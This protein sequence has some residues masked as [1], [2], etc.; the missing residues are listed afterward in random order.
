[1]KFETFS[2]DSW[3]GVFDYIDTTSRVRTS[4]R[5]AYGLERANRAKSHPSL[6]GRLIQAHRT[7]NGT[8]CL[9]AHSFTFS[10]A[11]AE[12][13]GLLLPMGI[14][15][16][17]RAMIVSCSVEGKLPHWTLAVYLDFKHPV[18]LWRDK[19]EPVWLKT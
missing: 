6:A 8:Y 11:F 4:Y 13:V 17:N 3:Q 9:Q 2:P 18:V 16:Q 12:H 10:E 1:M 7:P 19:G 5:R 14:S 15:P